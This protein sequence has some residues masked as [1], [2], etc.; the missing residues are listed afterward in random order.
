MTLR[1]L[2]SL[3]PA[4]FHRLA[5]HEH[6]GP[7]GAPTLICVHGLTRNG[8]DFAA[9]A[10][11]LS[12]HY[13]VICPDMPGRGQ[14]ENLPDP[15]QYAFPTYLADLAVLI[16]RLDVE[17]VDWVGTSMGGLLGMTMA[18]QPGSP[19]R[20]LVLNDVGAVVAQAGLERIAGYVGRDPGFATLDALADSMA[21][22][23]AG[24][25]KLPRAT[26]LAL[27][28]GAS[29]RRADGLLGFAYDPRIGDAMRAAPP[30]AI[31]LWARW[32]R[33][34]C[35]TLALRGEISD[36]LD[37]DVAQEMTRRGPRAKLVEIPGVGHAPW[38]S[39]PDEIAPVADFRL[40]P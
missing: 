32:D 2:S 30:Q 16:A 23:F 35:P 37:A 21:A 34:A 24:S 13:R 5:Y 9:L 39:T 15:A 33:V 26:L 4:G 25:A 11:A 10:R 38:L 1:Y 7:P 19:I 22:G 6:A 17:R 27:A 28:E 29:R 8:R 36:L 20:R 31:D 40:V 3:G 12:A 14:S 18:A